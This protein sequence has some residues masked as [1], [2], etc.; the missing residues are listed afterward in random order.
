MSQSDTKDSSQ[1]LNNRSFNPNFGMYEV[2]AYGD[3]GDGTISAI[4]TDKTIN[5]VLY[6]TEY[7]ATYNYIMK[8]KRGTTT[9]EIQRETISTG[10]REYATA[11]S[12]LATAWTDRAT[13]TYGAA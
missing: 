3:N 8:Y 13:Q 10:L 12:A 6:A 11:T 9:W 5:Q 1:S 2:I 4:S 7:G